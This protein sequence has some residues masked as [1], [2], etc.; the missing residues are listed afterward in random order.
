M[1][2]RWFLNGGG[3]NGCTDRLDGLV[4]NGAGS[5]EEWPDTL[6]A[7]VNACLNAKIP[8]TVLWGPELRMIYND[9]YREVLG[10]Y[11]H[12]GAM[13]ATGE[14]C[15]REVWDIAGA[16]AQR[17]LSNRRKLFSVNFCCLR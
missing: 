14:E 13:G 17:S 16:F 2:K 9:R 10:P 1:T 12:P 3:E 6:K 15:W 4:G 7:S 5:I 11:K 8:I